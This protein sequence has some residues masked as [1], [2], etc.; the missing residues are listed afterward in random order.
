MARHQ[1]DPMEGLVCSIHV[2]RGMIIPAT[3]AVAKET[4]PMPAPAN[5]APTVVQT[6]AWAAGS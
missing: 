3:I 6:K 5:T 1:T 2:I 4:H